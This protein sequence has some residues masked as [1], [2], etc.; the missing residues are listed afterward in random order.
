E[1]PRRAAYLAERLA[2]P[3][4][5]RAGLAARWAS[6]PAA[7]A[8]AMLAEL[9]VGPARHVVVFWVDL[10]GRSDVYNRPGEASGENWVLRV[11]PD[12]EAAFARALAAGEAPSLPAA[13][14][15]ALAA[16]GL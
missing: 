10:F 1:A 9:F 5:E 4:A 13:L 16:R 12:F 11:A 8:L 2:P 14:A 3:P 7:L 6:D 15:L